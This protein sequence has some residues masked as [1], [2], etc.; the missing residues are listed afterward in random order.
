MRVRSRWSW[1][2]RASTWP[3]CLRAVCGSGQ[4]AGLKTEVG[5]VGPSL[6][7]A[8]AKVNTVTHSRAGSMTAGSVTATDMRAAASRP[9]P[10]RRSRP[11]RRGLGD[12]RT[13]TCTAGRPG[14]AETSGEHGGAGRHSGSSRFRSGCSSTSRILLVK[15]GIG[16]VVSSVPHPRWAVCHPGDTTSVGWPTAAASSRW[17]NSLAGLLTIRYPWAAIHDSSPA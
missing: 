1:P 5:D 10:A 2:E 4:R 9:R 11:G 15:V 7:N 16:A 6:R 8:P 13:A 14:E 3:R 12:Q 17:S